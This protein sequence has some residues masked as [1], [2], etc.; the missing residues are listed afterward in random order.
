MNSNINRTLDNASAVF[1][2]TP[3]NAWGFIKDDGSM[4]GNMEVLDD[5]MNNGPKEVARSTL[6]KRQA[7]GNTSIAVTDASASVDMSFKGMFHFHCFG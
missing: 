6:E 2:Y 4:S 7:A 5:Y 3:E 1:T